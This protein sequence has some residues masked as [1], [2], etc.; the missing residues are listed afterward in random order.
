[1]VFIGY[2][3]NEACVLFPS[4]GEGTDFFLKVPLKFARLCIE[5]DLDKQKEL[6]TCADLYS[7]GFI[8][9]W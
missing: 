5:N 7:I 6:L 3:E 9:C 1:M 8:F 2:F 4:G